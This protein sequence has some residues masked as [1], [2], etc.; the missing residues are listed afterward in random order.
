L[1]ARIHLDLEHR[2]RKATNEDGTG[3]DA[4]ERAYVNEKN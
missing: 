3:H 2:A 4:P 1:A